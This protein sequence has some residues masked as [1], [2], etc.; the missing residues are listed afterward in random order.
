MLHRIC[1]ILLVGLFLTST[2]VGQV[3]LRGAVNDSETGD[4]IV[5][6]TIQVEGETHGVVTNQQGRFFLIINRIPS[7]LIFR[8][9]GY[10]S[11]SIVVDNVQDR[12][13]S[14]ALDPVVLELEELV[15]SGEDPAVGI[16]RRVLAQKQRWRSELQSAYAEVYTRFWLFRQF[17]PVQMSESIRS[18]YW[19][20]ESGNRE[21][22]R[23]R[24]VRPFGSGT[25]RFAGPRYI[26]NFYD[27]Q[28][29]LNGSTYVTPLHPNA[30]DYYRFR[31]GQKRKRDDTIVWD[32]YFTPL[33]GTRTAFTGRIAIL[34]SVFVALEIEARPHPG[35]EFLP[36]VESHDVRFVQ[37]F[38][39]LPGGGRVPLDLLANGSVTFG[40]L[41]A[42]YPPAR[43]EQ[44][45]SISNYAVNVPTPDS[46]FEDSRTQRLH[47]LA[48]HQDYL[49]VR[50]P[51]IIPLT[52]REAESMAALDP[53]MTIERAFRAYGF[54]RAYTAIDVVEEEADADRSVSLVE[55]AVRH[56][57]LWYNR[58][59]GWHPGL[60]TT[61]RSR[62]GY[63]FS[64]GA[65]YASDRRKP[66]ARLGIGIPWSTS[67]ILGELFFQASDVTEPVAGESSHGLFIPGLMTY[68]G[69]DEYYDFYRNRSLLVGGSIGS[70]SESIKLSVA[71]RLEKHLSVSRNAKFEGSI[72]HNA[73]GEN[74]PIPEGVI[75]SLGATLKV[76]RNGQELEMG[77]EH[78]SSG[79]MNSDF[80]YTTYRARATIR[81]RTFFRNRERPNEFRL[82][83]SGM[84]SGG[85]PPIQRYG[86]IDGSTG[87]FARSGVFRTLDDRALIG[88]RYAA[89]FWEHD[90]TTTLMERLG[91]WGLADTGSGLILFG[92]HGRI[93][94]NRAG[95]AGSAGLP[96]RHEA[97][98]A[99]TYP[100]RLPIRLDFSIRLDEPGFGFRLGRAR[101]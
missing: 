39:E 55:M 57:W 77:L 100:F 40:R 65:G 11:R 67:R 8:H 101:L 76:S 15:V 25:F 3:R 80:D 93:F 82:S 22:I 87:P 84:T 28:V 17:R 51:T 53:R 7:T 29:D 13:L 69:Y 30:L 48:D 73:Q 89:V 9:I 75:A 19:R 37:H 47:P 66:T 5:G 72:F 85:A 70:R 44:V 38:V 1:P 56:A 95:S 12:D 26:P 83:L 52:P 32:I 88:S 23:A 99:L 4:P 63:R 18:S 64:A 50:N 78:A 96:W 31:L 10:R 36:P 6:A 33:S 49:F 92:G 62:A 71:S 43:Y 20:P 27:D 45:S 97:G 35:T 16:M 54:L 68:A 61:W 94:R 81:V 98:V 59:D 86:R 91:L 21:L 41:G 79:W 2:V 58:V 42:S 46:M 24:R 34:D 60:Q 14:V 90:F 74:P